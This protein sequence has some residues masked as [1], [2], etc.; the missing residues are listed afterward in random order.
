MML[1]HTPYSLHTY[2]HVCIITCASIR[3]RCTLKTREFRTRLLYRIA[4]LWFQTIQLGNGLGLLLKQALPYRVHLHKRFFTYPCLALPYVNT[5]NNA[6]SDL[7]IKGFLTDAKHRI[8]FG[9][10]DIPLVFGDGFGYSIQTLISFL[11]IS[12]LGMLVNQSKTT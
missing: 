12:T 7:A 10:G 8:G 2:S 5:W 3:Y 1:V 9:N 6:L 11:F 4:I